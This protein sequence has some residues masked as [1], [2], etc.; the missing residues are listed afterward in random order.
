[1][2]TYLKKEKTKLRVREFRIPR[3]VSVLGNILDATKLP[4]GH[5]CCSRCHGYKFEASGYPGGNKIELGC[6]DCNERIYLA[7]PIDVVVPPGRYGCWKH[8]NKGMIVIHNL[9][10]LCIGCES[11]KSEIRIEMKKKDGIIIADA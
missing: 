7:F 6:V 4:E 10:V 2:A 5:L 1:M 9:D 11:C 3:A 8:S